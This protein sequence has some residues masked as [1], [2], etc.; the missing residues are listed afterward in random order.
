[1]PEILSPAGSLEKLYYAIAYGADAVYL[2]AKKFGM[3]TAS[4]NFSEKELL[5]ARKLCKE[6]NIK[7]YIT[8]NGFLHNE[9]LE[10][11]KIFL[12]KKELH[13]D[14]YIISDLG[15][16]ET[17]RK[18]C[19]I[20]IHLSTQ[21]SCLNS[22]QANFW[23]DKGVSRIVL[24]RESTV[25]EA[26][27][28]KEKTNIEIEMFIHGSTCM[29]YSGHCVI[30]NYTQGRDS[31]RGGC[32]HSCRFHYKEKGTFLSSKDMY[33]LDILQEFVKY[34][35]DSLKIEG[36]MKGLLYLSV[37]TLAYK[38]T[39][40]DPSKAIFY[41]KLL[42]KVPNRELSHLNILEKTYSE[43]HLERQAHSSHQFLGNIIH[44]EGDYAY[45]DVKNSF[46]LN[47][48]ATLISPTHIEEISLDHIY[49][50]D[51]QEIQRTKPSTVVKLKNKSL[52]TYSLIVV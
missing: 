43:V 10:F 38:Q 49:D 29:S 19:D 28:I 50:L 8:L 34:G 4:S 27:K 25:Q 14:A 21:A 11:L 15:V 41:K 16:I 32:C 51:H 7:Q 46:S 40:L 42:D 30:S 20:P 48:K 45:M 12:K 6:N 35:I 18:E 23:K 37:A 2:S 33:S 3:R 31:N 5:L 52:E 22:Y 17:V 47:Q 24:G 13:P 39:L 36:R 26:A 9:D 44:Q 1:M